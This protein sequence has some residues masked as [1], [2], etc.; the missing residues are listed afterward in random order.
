MFGLPSD[1]DST[2]AASAVYETW[3]K[4]AYSGNF[5]P[6]DSEVSYCWLWIGIIKA[7]VLSNTAGADVESSVDDM[8]V[9]YS[10][11]S[12]LYE[13]ASDSWWSK[14]YVCFPKHSGE[15]WRSLLRRGWK[16]DDLLAQPLMWREAEWTDLIKGSNIG[17]TLLPDLYVYSCKS[18]YIVDHSNSR[19]N[20]V[21]LQGA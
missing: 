10:E 2:F 11:E 7:R 12:H 14:V 20:R 4:A 15:I 8:W 21:L 13:D 3:L 18:G 1:P 5:A 9:R 6:I 19:W 17:L 16:S